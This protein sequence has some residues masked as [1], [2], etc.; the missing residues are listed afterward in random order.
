MESFTVMGELCEFSMVVLEFEDM[1]TSSDCISSEHRN[2]GLG[3]LFDITFYS[4][5]VF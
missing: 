4:L 3:D 1:T 5:L 2:V